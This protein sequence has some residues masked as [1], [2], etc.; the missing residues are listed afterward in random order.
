MK[1]DVLKTNLEGGAM[2]VKV[3]MQ[4][5]SKPVNHINVINTYTK[6]G[7]FVI[8]M[9]Q[10]V[11]HKY[12]LCNIFRITESQDIGTPNTRLIVRKAF[13]EVGEEVTQR[14]INVLKGCEKMTRKEVENMLYELE[15]TIFQ[16]QDN[17]EKETK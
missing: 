7:V 11:Y 12:P 10:G 4:S 5:Q 8:E 13:D 17:L 3:H 15:M 16:I 2:T 6:E 14:R 9:G 1:Q